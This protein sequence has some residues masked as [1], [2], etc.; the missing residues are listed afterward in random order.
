VSASFTYTT[1]FGCRQDTI[2]CLHDGAHNVNLWSWTFNNNINISTAS[3]TLF[4]PAASTTQVRL[5]V[6]NGF[7]SDSFSTSLVMDNEVKAGF[8]MPAVICP[9]DA[10]QVTD[11]SKGLIDAWHWSFG[12]IST[13]NLRRAL[14]VNFPANNIETFYPVKLRVTNNSLGCTDSVTRMLRVLNNCFIAVP[15]AFTPNNDGLNDFLYPNNAIKAK[16]LEFKVYNRW[17]QLVFHSNDWQKKWD[18]RVGGIPQA[19]GVFVWFLKY[20]HITTGQQVFQK[21]TTTL[22]R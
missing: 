11:T 10:L 14:P 16:D 7:C 3:H 12:N 13:S 6:S 17:G 22:I 19:P 8:D 1:Q 4:V 9:E 21:G 15:S 18:G 5:F 20:T 2:T